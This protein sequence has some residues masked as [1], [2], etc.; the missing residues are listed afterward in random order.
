MEPKDD[1]DDEDVG[2]NLDPG[3]IPGRK[4]FEGG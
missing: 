3:K 4:R 2:L 1:D